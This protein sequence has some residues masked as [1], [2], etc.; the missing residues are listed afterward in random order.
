[1]IGRDRSEATFERELAAAARSMAVEPLPRDVLDAP[2]VGAADGR[3]VA[4]ARAVIAVAAAIVLAVWLGGR[5]LPSVGGGQDQLR[6]AREI[7]NELQGAGYSCTQVPKPTPSGAPTPEPA[8]SPTPLI[9]DIVCS[10]P[11]NLQ[12]VVGAL[13]LEQDAE[14]AVRL[15]HVKAGVLGT[16]TG[17]AET[18][19]GLLLERLT[20]VAFGDPDDAATIRAWVRDHARLEVGERV[21][22]TVSGV[23]VVL[24]RD[25]FGGYQAELTPPD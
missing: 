13:V 10:T 9:L 23:E 24:F 21:E 22:I 1:M 12:P 15:A 3:A 2:A 18:N 17:S 7:L 4:I 16:P 14:G 11:G 19:R 8:A 5:L 20:S 6:P 25:D